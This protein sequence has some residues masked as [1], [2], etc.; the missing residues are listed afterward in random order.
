MRE[1]RHLR[2]AIAAGA[3][4]RDERNRRRYPLGASSLR[5]LISLLAAF[6]DD[7]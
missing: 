5:K 3:E 1:S 2:A 7:P 4:L 6:L